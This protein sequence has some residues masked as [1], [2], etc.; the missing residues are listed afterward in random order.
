MI[1]TMWGARVRACTKCL[2]TN[3]RFKE[4][5]SYYTYRSYGEE[6]YKLL[7][8]IQVSR[9]TGMLYFNL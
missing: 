7:P 9:K 5:N 2:E 1:Q 4:T 3:D 8:S 6:L